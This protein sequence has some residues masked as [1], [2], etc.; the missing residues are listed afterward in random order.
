M[1]E[2]PLWKKFILLI[3]K[4]FNGYL[5]KGTISIVEEKFINL[6]NNKVVSNWEKRCTKYIFLMDHNEKEEILIDELS[7]AQ[8]DEII[9]LRFSIPFIF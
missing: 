2:N 7:K 6:C 8:K 5:D 9:Y 1:K 4:D 3:N